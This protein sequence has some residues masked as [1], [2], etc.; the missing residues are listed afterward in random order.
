MNNII[1][2]ILNGKKARDVVLQESPY[3]ESMKKHYPGGK[4]ETPINQQVAKSAESPKNS[5][6]ITPANDTV[7]PRYQHANGDFQPKITRRVSKDY[8][9]SI[10]KK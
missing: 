1:K 6:D 9:G 5:A 4:D 8:R 10:V 2:E 7:T 3:P